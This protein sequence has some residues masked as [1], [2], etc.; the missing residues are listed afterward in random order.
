MRNWKLLLRAL[1]VASALVLLSTAWGLADEV[2]GKIRGTVSD[3]SGA[4][5]PGTTVKATNVATGITKVTRAGADG[6]YEFLQLDAPAD[7]NVT[8][9]HAGFKAFQASS[10]HLSLNQVYVLDIALEVG[11]VTQ[12]V[13]VQAA[14]VQVERTS[15]QL[16]ARLT[17]SAIVDLP[18][19]GRDWIN[20]QKTLPG[21]VESID[22]D[23]S[24]ATN[25]SRSQENGFLINGTDNNDLALNVPNAIPSPDAIAEVNMITST[26]NPEYG[27]SSGAILNAETKSGTNKFHGS[28]FEFYRDPFLNTRNFFLPEPEQFHQNQFG[29]TIGGPIKKDKSFF[30]FSYQGTRNRKPIQ[31][32][33]GFAGGTTTVFSPDQRNGI[34]PDLAASSS[35]SPF[36]LV[37]ESGSTLCPGTP[38]PAGTPYST[39]F[40]TGHIPAADYNPI[41]VNLINQYMPLPNF[42]AT[43][44]SWNPISVN[45]NYQ[46]IS[47][48]DHSFS[49]KDSLYGYWFVEQD[50]GVDDEPFFGG[51]LPGFGESQTARVQNMNL[52]WNHTFGASAINEA[53]VGYNRLGFNTVNPVK[54]TLPSSLGFTGIKPQTTAGAGLPCIDMIFYEPPDGACLFG[55]S[56]DGPQPR[57]DQT[58]QVSDN[59]TWIHG[60]H[61]FKVGF[62][63]R[64]AQVKNPFYFVNNGYFQF[65]GIGLYSTG[66]SGA[67]FLLGIPDFYEQTSGGFIDARTRQYYSYFQDQWKVRSNLTLTYGLGWQVN[68]PQNDIFNGGLAVNAF[69]P[70]MQS[71]VYPTAPP[72]L[73][74]PGD[75]GLSTSTYG[76]SLRHFGPRL[77]FAWSPDPARKWSIRAGFGTYYNQIEEE[78]TLQN[79][80]SPPFSL[81][82][83]GVFD[84][85]GSPSFKDPY[86]DIRTGGFINNKFPFTPPKPGDKT[87]DFSFFY[88]MVLKVFDPHLTTPS[89]YNYNFTVQRELPGATIV[90]IGYVGHQGRHLEQRYELDPPGQAPGINP[91]CA[92]D[93]GCIPSN[94]GFTHPETFRYP[95]TTAFAFASVGTQ[96]TDANSNYNSFQVTATKHT[97]HGLQFQSSY[98]WSHSLDTTSSVENVGGFGAPNPFNMRTNY[99]DSSYD[100]RHRFV[101]GYSYEIPSARHFNSLHRLPSR[102]TEGW[103]F[104]GDTTFQTGF[105]LGL[106]DSSDNSLTCWQGFNSYGCADRPNVVGPVKISDPRNT[107]LVNATQGGTRLRS[108]YYFDP[109][110]FAPEVR[111]FLGSAGRNWFHGPGIN[112]WD[113]GF[114]KDTRLTE[115]TRIEVRFEFFNL[116]NHTQFAEVGTDINTSSFGRARAAQQ[117]RIIQLAAKFYF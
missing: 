66:D 1:V 37:G 35:K 97:T 56:Y 113:L 74:F 111:G 28:G 94:V 61:T 27:R 103:R 52:T 36:A 102:L 46:Y 114:Y 87:L 65:Y 57:I 33:R 49:T 81:T 96:A 77:G 43:D 38:C 108:H 44:F 68:T 107:N 62:D 82:D 30:F 14:P 115:S 109:N 112:V 64:R 45:K 12:E 24:F 89:A 67:D 41:S 7:Y 59:F 19:D 78:L 13:T 31:P 69:R 117:S 60:A 10:V 99:G 88:P 21:V 90:S 54:P 83:F 15:T 53:R 5:V 20:L 23:D 63:M 51:S 39:I 4:V 8:A 11:T 84:V 2:G 106:T 91:V 86:T 3:S 22:F 76:T 40:P 92:A 58:Y 104:A 42:G 9:T 25:G 47:R 34:F 98:T 26:I 50:R 17:G 80:Q 95:N 32:G 55:F 29:G 6:I 73:L 105:P 116:F 79:L 100:A 71:S 70:G 18:L 48:I 16:G 93:P 101:I 75:Q 72:G 85:G 110:S